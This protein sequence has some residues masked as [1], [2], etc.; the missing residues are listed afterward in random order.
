MPSE[1]AGDA[2]ATRRNHRPPES[3]ALNPLF[4]RPP[5]P[6][7]ILHWYRAYWMSL[8]TSTLTV[9]F[10]VFAFFA[11]LPP[12]ETM[13]VWSLDW[14]L[15]VYLA[16]LFPHCIFA[17]LLHYWLYMRQGQGRTFKFDARDQASDNGTFTFRDQ[18]RDN[19][20]WTIASGITIWTAFQVPVYWAMANGWTPVILFPE[21]P[22]WFLAMFPFLVIWSSFQIYWIHRALHIPWLYRIARALHHR[23]VNVGPW[24][25]ISMHPVEHILFFT[26]FLIHY[27]VP[28]HHIHVLFHGYM[29]ATHP[30]FSNS[31][32]EWIYVRNREC[33]K[34]SDFFHQL[35]HRYFDCSYGTVEMPWDRWFGSFHDG[36]LEATVRT[37]ARKNLMHMCG[38]LS[39]PA[40]DRN[41]SDTRISDLPEQSDKSS[42]IFVITFGI[43][44][45]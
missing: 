42:I 5:R 9:A 19:M 38:P 17:G 6:L 44:A 4:S 18:V 26:N 12:L 23:N 31:G 24:S 40:L 27:V 8:T 3:V 28:S 45:V 25:G 34:A 29:Q 39:G 32:F 36:S 13:K 7:A 21:N 41:Y 10:A 11:I 30:A 2:E 33:A 15:R 20:F 43:R 1:F 22:A 16:N 14:V 37:R 35:H